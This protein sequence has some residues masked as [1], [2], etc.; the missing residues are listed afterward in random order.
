MD[1]CVQQSETPAFLQGLS[2]NHTLAQDE[3][4]TSQL[5]I[6]ARQFSLVEEDLV[7]CSARRKLSL[8]SD[9][10]K[11][12][13]LNLKQLFPDVQIL[14]DTPSTSD[15]AQ[16]KEPIAVVE[17]GL[18]RTVDDNTHWFNIATMEIPT[19]IR[20][21][22]APLKSAN[23]G[24]ASI[25]LKRDGNLGVLANVFSSSRLSFMEGLPS[26]VH[27]SACT[28]SAREQLQSVDLGT[29]LFIP[30]VFPIGHPSAPCPKLDFA[31][32]RDWFLEEPLTAA[33]SSGAEALQMPEGPNQ[34]TL[35]DR[36]SHPVNFT[37]SQ[38]SLAEVGATILDGTT[39]IRR[40]STRDAIR[41]VSTQR[42]DAVG[43]GENERKGPYLYERPWI[44]IPNMD[45]VAAHLERWSAA[46]GMTFRRVMFEA[47]PFAEQVATVRSTRVLVGMEGAGLANMVF[48]ENPAKSAVVELNAANGKVESWQEFPSISNYLGVPLWMHVFRCDFVDP[49]VGVDPS[50]LNATMG[51]VWRRLHL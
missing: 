36:E 51:E 40:A 8:N 30:E 37:P 11:A 17:E 21:V 34:V 27:W 2:E 18:F 26:C 5:L 15:A 48:F 39:A 32:V 20:F 28:N 49:T 16:W 4:S 7:R 43:S 35:I 23:R 9:F 3:C 29:V 31:A 50:A 6:E 14:W 1:N 41:R 12:Y 46:H 33:G 38:T 45:E 22:L 10:H 19:L 44:T 25:M 24:N 42:G 13:M 47:L